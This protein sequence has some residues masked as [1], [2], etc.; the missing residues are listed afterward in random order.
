MNDI[1]T[2]AR[3]K[4][5]V[6]ALEKAD[7]QRYRAIRLNALQRAPMS[8]GSTFEEENAY[9]DTIFARRL[10]QVDGNAIF[11]AFHGEELL[12]IAGHHRH[13]RR[14]ERHRGTLA[15]VYVEPQAR[16]LKLGEALVQKVI[17][18]AARH[19]VV[20]DARVVAT[21]EA[22]KRIYYAL[23]FKTCGVERKALLVQGQYLDQELIYIDFSDLAWK[24][25]L[26]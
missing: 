19:V 22:A 11:G 10:E 26:G 17:D 24:D 16:G 2:I 7:L 15:S 5:V 9:S 14:T 25:K 3:D 6:R 8:F 12:G 18:H 23:G 20:L 1:C 13:E 21:N 4:V